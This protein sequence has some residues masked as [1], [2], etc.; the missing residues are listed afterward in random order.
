M[1]FV[2][3]Q[4]RSAVGH[5]AA[6]SVYQVYTCRGGRYIGKTTA[7]RSTRVPGIVAR[8]WE[9]QSKIR[10]HSSEGRYRALSQ[11]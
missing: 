10:L 8:F 1:R 9:H 2:E 5:L 3:L 6:G 11:C 7:L 4:F